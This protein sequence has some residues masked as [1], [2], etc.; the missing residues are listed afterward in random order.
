MTT[1]LGKTAF[2]TGAA[3]GIGR[4]SAI[5]LARQGAALCLVDNQ[6][7]RLLSL[8]E[9][10]ES[11]QG[12]VMTVTA[13]VTDSNAVMDAFAQFAAWGKSLDILF[14]NAGV[15]GLLTTIEDMPE[16][17]WDRIMAVNLKGAFLTVKH[18]IPLMKKKGGNVIL[19]SSIHG[20]R[21][22]NSYGMTVY[23]TSKAGLTAFAKAAALELA[24]YKIRVNVICPG[25]IDTTI[26]DCLVR[27]DALS[28][29]IIP[30]EYPEGKY[31]FGVGK[32][33]QIADLVA[34]LASEQA[35]YISGTEIYIDGARS[36]I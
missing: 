22:F 16:E 9:E 27:S 36:L 32:A 33:D 13:D 4:A 7:D 34:F 30:V 11:L 18:A 14:S 12:E 24:R 1:L 23:S 5:R 19:T 20:N 28:E 15:A 3:L 17:E 25:A 2:I 29:V 10:I 6:A 35:S 31:P 26:N 21:I 8:K